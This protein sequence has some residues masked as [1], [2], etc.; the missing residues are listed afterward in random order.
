[1]RRMPWATYLWPGLPEV[2]AHGSWSALALAASMG[3][4]LNLALLGSY[5]WDDLFSPGFRTLLWVAV[6][7]G[8]G[9]SGF[10]AWL[11]DGREEVPHVPA[12]EADTFG[13]AQSHYLR[14]DWYRAERLLVAL[15]QRD[16][17]DVDARMM[18]ASV[19][20]HTG[21]HA[22]SR[23]QLDQLDRY[24]G[25]RKWELE[26]ARERALLEEAE[27]Q[28]RAAQE[29]AQEPPCEGDTGE[30]DRFVDAA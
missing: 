16:V 14:G 12:P 3:L 25:S 17:R 6:A 9:V 8:W 23:H 29:T 7:L 13:E 2:W 30:P 27:T 4:L 1:M 5:G 19:Y 11:R 15:L 24:E 20:R 21:R 18:L 26:I 28:P 10:L 22:E